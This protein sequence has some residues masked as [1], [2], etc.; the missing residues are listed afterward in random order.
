[1]MEDLW[2]LGHADDSFGGSVLGSKG[3][4]W[5]WFSDRDEVLDYL[6]GDYVDLLADTGELDD[7][8]LESA[9]DRFTD[10]VENCANDEQL[11]H[12]LNELSVELRRI[13]WFGSLSELAT[14][15]RD[16]AMALRHYYWQ[17]LGEED[18]PDAAV[19]PEQWGELVEVLD[20]FLIDGDYH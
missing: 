16:F 12:E 10:L 6:L 8:Q 11:V 13:I 18:E 3:T 9:R 2:A 19:E 17:Q 5:L 7:E 4:Q 15:Y 1:M 14:G 20:G